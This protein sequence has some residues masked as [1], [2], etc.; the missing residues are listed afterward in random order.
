VESDTDANAFFLNG[1]NG[2]V[3]IG[4]ETPE[5][6]LHVSSSSSGIPFVV[7]GIGASIPG[8]FFDNNDSAT[9][10][11]FNL[12]D[13]GTFRVSIDG[14]GIQEFAITS[15]G[16]VGIGTESPTATLD[17]ETSGSNPAL[18]IGGTYNSDI[19]ID[20]TAVNNASS[21]VNQ[22][23]AATA[24][25]DPQGTVSFWLGLNNELG[26]GGSTSNS[27][28]TVRGQQASLLFFDSYGGTVNTFDG[29]RAAQVSNSG[30]GSPILTTY[31][32]FS[33][34]GNTFATNN[35][36]FVGEINDAAN[37]HNLYMS[38]TADNYIEGNVGIGTT[39]PDTKLDVV[40]TIVSSNQL[41]SLY[42]AA[43]GI[44]IGTSFTN[45]TWD[46][47][48]RED[49]LFSHSADSDVITVNEAGD[50]IIS[51]SCT[52]DSSDGANRLHSDWRIIVNSVELGGTR[53]SAYHRISADGRN[54]AALTS[55][56]HTFSAND[57]VTLQGQSDDA[58]AIT[59]VANGCNIYLERK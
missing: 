2:N 28:T 46:T 22:V 23:M 13:T 33:V 54:T 51:Y 44:T 32:G 59:T 17:I 15:A 4:T 45:I 47:E 7:E 24:K 35:R 25:L 6:V 34:A 48:P 18:N 31:N 27:V 53:R 57:I 58:T 40:G 49:A 11:S 12:A 29:F 9:K 21:G 42:D 3:G 38:G 30:S 20:I 50:Y 55:L 37:A 36:G 5:R 1:T 52:A 16:D 26:I 8:V 41:I 39:S 43:G 14:S 10:W 56:L 19:L